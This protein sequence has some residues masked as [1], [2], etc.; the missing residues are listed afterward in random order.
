MCITR[1]SIGETTGAEDVAI[2]TVARVT[3]L[4]SGIG[5][6]SLL[7]YALLPVGRGEF[8]ICI[9]FAGLLGVLLTP[10]AD[11]GAQYFVMARRISISQGVSVSLLIC[12]VGAA[13]A[14]SLAIP[15]INSD[16]DFF[17]KADS[18][19]FLLSL[20][21]L[22]LIAFSSAVQHQIAGLRRFMHLA[23]FSL[24]Q[25]VSNALAL[26]SLVVG[27]RFGVSGAILSAYVSNLVM[28]TCCLR[29]LAKYEGFK[30]ELPSPSCL[31]HVVRYGIRYYIARIGWGM[32]VRVGTLLLGMFGTRAEVGLFA[33]A[34]TLMMSFISIASAVSIALLPRTARDEDGRAGLVVFCARTMTWVVGAALVVLI[35]FD[36][37]LVRLLLSAEFLPVVPLIRIIAPGILVYAGASVF[38]TYFRGTN[39]PDMCSWA[40]GC[41]FGMTVAIVVLFYPEVGV[42]A[43][44]W[45]MTVGLFGRS[46]LLSVF[47]Y[48]MTKTRPTLG[49]LPQRGDISRFRTLVRSAIRRARGR[50]SMHV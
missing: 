40:V 47:F 4:L 25:T 50:S 34:S 6:Q 39:R 5:I 28:I 42:I 35:A 1:P 19:S 18:S 37:S 41:G 14:T 43:S 29:D 49:W 20:G 26:V 9:L 7:A 33:V 45:G 30:F 36:I 21:L 48:R 3:T 22:P 11:A 10:G 8:A 46:A 15:L 12:V 13:L 23:V 32:D 38:A 17:R 24:I 44:A 2:N 27:L 16:I 31:S